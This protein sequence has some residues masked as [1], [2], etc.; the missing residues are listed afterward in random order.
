L[1]RTTQFD[2][3]AYTLEL[4]TGMNIKADSVSHGV[5]GIQNYL[6]HKQILHDPELTGDSS[7]DPTMHFTR[8]SQVERYYAPRGGVIQS[9]IELGQK[10]TQ[11]QLLYELLSFAKEEDF[12]SVTSITAQQTGIVFDVSI[13]EAVNEGEYVLGIL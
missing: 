2:V 11:G 13:N 3:E 8:S 9:R 6:K 1:G 10:V 7:N 4:G 5:A 12:P